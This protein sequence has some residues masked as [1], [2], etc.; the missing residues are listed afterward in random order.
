[1]APNTSALADSGLAAAARFQAGDFQGA[2][3]RFEQ[4]ERAARAE[5]DTSLADGLLNNVGLCRLR[6]GDLDGA[7]R[8]FEQVIAERPLAFKSHYNL[9]R[10]LAARGRK[11]E[12]I[13]SYERALAINPSAPGVRAELEALRR[14]N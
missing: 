6:L 3:V 11:D 12:A 4:L 14:S 5:G 2:L 7:T 10:V 9:G 8:A 13:A 1:M